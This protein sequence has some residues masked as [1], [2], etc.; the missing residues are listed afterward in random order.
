MTNGIRFVKLTPTGEFH[1]GVELMLASDV[2]EDVKALL[3]ANMLTPEMFGN[4][5]IQENQAVQ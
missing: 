2:T 1:Q 3:S 5:H 4:A